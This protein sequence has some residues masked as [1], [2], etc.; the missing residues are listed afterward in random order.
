MNAQIRKTN[1]N[2]CGLKDFHNTITVL[3]LQVLPH[4]IYDMYITDIVLFKY[5][6]H[7]KTLLLRLTSSL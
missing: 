2:F 6:K 1:D 5:N 7:M 3:V 4:Y